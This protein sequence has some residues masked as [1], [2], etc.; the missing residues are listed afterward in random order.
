MP[1]SNDSSSVRPPIS[2]VRRSSQARLLDRLAAD[3]TPGRLDWIGLR[4]VRRG[5]I[6][7]V[8]SV[9][10]L[11]EQGLQGDHRCR[12]T[13]GS[14]RQVTIISREFIE[15]IC[16]HTGLASIDPALLRRNLV[17]SGMNLNLLRHQILQIG[18]AII[19]P[20]ALCHPCS[21]MNENLGEGGVAAMYGYGGLCAKIV[22]S[23]TIAVGD[24]VVRLPLDTELS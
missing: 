1:V 13:R 2:G 18:E 6:A 8:E 5:E 4:T 15:Q 20:G 12:K 21:R 17:I 9:Q 24:A 19:V 14:G 23:G 10:A 11:A 7:E 22:R 3:I 16:R